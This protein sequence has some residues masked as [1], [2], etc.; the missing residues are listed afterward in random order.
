M[1]I[2]GNFSDLLI[3]KVGIF[4]VLVVKVG[5]LRSFC[6]KY[7]LLSKAKSCLL[8]LTGFSFGFSFILSIFHEVWM[9]GG[10]SS[11]FRYGEETDFCMV[12]SFTPLI[13][14]SLF[15]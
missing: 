4:G 14:L 7:V 9:G 8:V 10:L 2:A 11:N 6:F 15:S 3:V 5:F 1:K 13:P 12:L